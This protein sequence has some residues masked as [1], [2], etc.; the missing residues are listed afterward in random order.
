MYVLSMATSL[1][2]FRAA[3][4]TEKPTATSHYSWALS[5]NGVTLTQIDHPKMVRLL[6]KNHTHTPQQQRATSHF[7]FLYSQLTDEEHSCETAAW[8]TVGA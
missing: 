8:L 6:D 2:S 7:Q 5:P 4:P 1:R 3:F